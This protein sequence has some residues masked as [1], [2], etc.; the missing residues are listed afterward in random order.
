MIDQKLTDDPLEISLANLGSGLTWIDIF[1]NESH[2][3]RLC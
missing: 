1:S 3:P 2:L